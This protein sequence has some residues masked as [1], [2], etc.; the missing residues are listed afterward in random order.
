MDECRRDVL[1][2]LRELSMES[3]VDHLL[4]LGALDAAT[5]ADRRDEQLREWRS[6]PLDALGDELEALRRRARQ[7]HRQAAV[8]LEEARRQRDDLAG[9]AT[10]TVAQLAHHRQAR[11]RRRGPDDDAGAGLDGVHRA[12]AAA[13]AAQA[14]LTEGAAYPEA[15]EG[16][17]LVVDQERVDGRLVLR[18]TG[19]IDIATAPRL[20]A[21][22]DATAGAEELWVDLVGVRFIDSTGISALLRATVGLGGPRRLA[23]I[24][25]DGPARRALELCGIGKV[26]A[27]YADGSSAAA[28]R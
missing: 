27:L 17:R 25:P 2:E 10:A 1:A 3:A 23:V 21:A 19:E 26:L 28:E 11:L 6:R 12:L 22:L 5:L 18:L 24:C 15:I 13:L 20:Q 9:T 16:S 4:E 8:L 7:Q 14:L